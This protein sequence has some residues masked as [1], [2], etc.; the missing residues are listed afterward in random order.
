MKSSVQQGFTLIELLLV[1]ALI[2]ILSSFLLPGFTNY[3]DSQNLNQGVEQIKSDLRSAQNKAISGVDAS[4]P[5]T[6]YWGLKFTE[7]ASVY[8]EF[9]ST[10]NS[11]CADITGTGKS[12]SLLGGVVITGVDVT[13]GGCVFF[14]LRNGDANVIGTVFPNRIDVTYPGDVATN[15]VEINSAGRI[16]GVDL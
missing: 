14:S 6:N 7:G 2:A 9:K 8:E 15:G 16:R 1:V 11:N 5:D 13:N 12:E 3:I 10:G 4:N